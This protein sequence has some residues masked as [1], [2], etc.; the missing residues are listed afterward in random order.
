MFDRFLN[1]SE[2][3]QLPLSNNDRCLLFLSAFSKSP[4]ESFL[5]IKSCPSKKVPAI[6]KC[7]L[8]SI[9]TIGK[10]CKLNDEVY[11]SID[12]FNF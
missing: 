8:F 3:D 10:F 5:F 6:K 2:T 4:C 11:L 7:S 1:A 9:F 12:T